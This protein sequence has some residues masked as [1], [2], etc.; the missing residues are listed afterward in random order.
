MM[1]K[2]RWAIFILGV[3]TLLVAMIQNSEPVQLT[4]L[5]YKAEMPTSILLLVVAVISFLVGAAT[6][7]WVM[8]RRPVAQKP[9]EPIPTPAASRPPLGTSPTATESATPPT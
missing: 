9:A 5:R 6:T 3:I 2:I 8:R 1:Q 7:G 4:F